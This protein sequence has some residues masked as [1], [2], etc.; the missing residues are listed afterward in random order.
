M[1]Y[2]SFSSLPP[3]EERQFVV[4]EKRTAEAAKSANNIGFGVATGLLVLTLAI[5]LGFWAPIKAPGVEEEQGAPPQP[6][7]SSPSKPAH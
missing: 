6:A 7:A 2:H 1:E 4:F 5:V 3:E